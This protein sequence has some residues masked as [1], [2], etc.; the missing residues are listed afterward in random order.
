MKIPES[1]GEDIS[2]WQIKSLDLEDLCHSKNPRGF[3]FFFFNLLF[4][5]LICSSRGLHELLFLLLRQITNK[6]TE[7]NKGLFCL[8][9][10]SLRQLYPPSRELGTASGVGK[11]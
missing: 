2:L 5:S 10:G 4:Y 1:G 7:G 8:H 9:L 11:W 3:F 6:S